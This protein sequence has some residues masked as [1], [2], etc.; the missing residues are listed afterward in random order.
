MIKV[1]VIVGP[2]ASGKTSLSI[3]LAKKLNGEV[4]SADSRQVYKGLDIGTG[5][6]TRKEMKGIKHHLLDVA[7][8]KKVFSVTDYVRLAEKAIEEIHSRG[9]IPII[10]G[11]TGFYIQALVDGLILPEVVPNTSLRKRLEKKDLPQLLNI[12]KKL[13]KRRFETIDQNNPRRIIRAIEI[14]TTLG[15]IPL[16][17][18]NSK[19]DPKFIGISLPKKILQRRIH[20]RLIDRLKAGMINEVKKLHA[21]GLSWKRMEELG[22][23]YRYISR[24]LKNGCD[25]SLLKELEIA[26]NQY[27]KRQ[28]TWFKKDK[29]IEWYSTVIKFGAR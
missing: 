20:K 21:N 8:P 15:K 10:C 25:T 1:I 16:L 22:L 12:L 9:K 23:E 29:R 24:Y 5:K 2:T 26:I 7:D 4:I 17:K 11:G 6:I 18:T 28:M 27:A 13:D 3:K 14:A 19:Y